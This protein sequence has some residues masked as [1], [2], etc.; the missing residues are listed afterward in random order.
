MDYIESIRKYTSGKQY[1]S[2]NIR[3]ADG[4]LAYMTSTGV[5]RVYPSQEVYDS[6]AKKNGCGGDFIQLTPNWA[7]LGFPVGNLM[8][9]G[10]AC[11]NETT[12]VQS[13]P[14]KMELDWQYYISSNPDL[15][16]TTEAEANEHWNTAGKQEGRLPSENAITSM[17]TLGKVG[18][19]DVNATMHQVPATYTGKYNTYPSVTNATGT[20]MVDCIRPIEPI[21]YGTQLILSFNDTTAFINTSSQLEFGS[22]STNFFLRPPVGVD[23]SGKPVKYGDEVSITS[24]T[25]SYTQNCGWWGCKVGRV[26]SMSNQVEFGPGGE[27]AT[28][29]KIM[30]P[31]GSVYTI[32]TELKVSDPFYIT[33]P[34]SPT[35]KSILHQESSLLPGTS[36]KSNNGKYIFIY[37]TDGNVCLYNIDGTSIWCSAVLHDPGKLT[38]QTN[39]NLAAFDSGGVPR[40]TTNT[41]GQGNGTYTLQISN[42]RSV[43]LL[44]SVDTVLW[45]TQTAITTTTSSQL[46]PGFAYVKQ[47]I[48]TLGTLKTTDIFSFK[49]QTE[50]PTKCNIDELRNACDLASCSGFIH[51]PDDNTWQMIT[52][53]NTDYSITNT[54]QDVYL[55]TGTVDIH[56]SSCQ[57]GIPS[58]IDAATYLNYT[59][60]DSFIDGGTSQCQVIQP[61][62][63]SQQFIDQRDQLIQ[64]GK[65]AVSKYK[66]LNVDE[67]QDQNVQLN[68]TM[69]LKTNEY[70]GVLKEIRKTSTLS[71]L[72]Q[73]KVDS[74]VFDDYNQN[75]VVLWSGLAFI[76]VLSVLIVPSKA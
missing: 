8:E 71:T 39:G 27:V 60:G 37:Q 70:R 17:Q 69:K 16:L 55:K 76:L 64:S 20:N 13:K 18:Y 73:Q 21:Q 49:P 59:P 31:S 53:D 48:V 57:S 5:S 10:K 30:P 23:M 25:S 14:E 35:T 42:D 33:S 72:E 6:T 24:S 38:L 56:D 36:I 46:I 15:N 41:G 34:F 54:V 75:R 28:T 4:T 65:D 19:I 3:S 1:A 32:G 22:T 12:Y 40:W 63:P 74:A 50:A 26:N 52:E 7:D 47:S 51:S 66:S 45:S 58:F 9:P 68:T 62:Q 67:V 43:D 11:G 29:F 61:P 2:S 44:D